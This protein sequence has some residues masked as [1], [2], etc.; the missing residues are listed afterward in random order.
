MIIDLPNIAP[1]KILELPVMNVDNFIKRYKC[2]EVKSTMIK[3]SSS[4]SFDPDGL[5]SEI[6]FGEV[7]TPLRFVKFGYVNL[8][9]K[10]L[11][12]RI[13]S[14]VCSIKSLYK[15]ILF[16]QTYAVF[17][18]KT[19]MFEA[20]SV[21]NPEADT[22]LTF[23]LKYFPKAI[24]TTSTSQSAQD[25]IQYIKKFMNSAIIDKWIISPPIMREFQEID[26]REEIGELNKI[27]RAIIMYARAIPEDIDDTNIFNSAKSGIQR[28][29]FEAYQFIYDYANGKKGA[30]ERILNRRNLANSTRNVISTIWYHP[31]ALGSAD[32]LNSKET[33]MP[34]FQTIKAYEPLMI[35]YLIHEWFIQKIPNDQ[36]TTLLYDMNLK[37]TQVPITNEMRNKYLNEDGIGK[38]I[39]NLTNEHIFWEDATIEINGKRYYLFTK[40][41]FENKFIKDIASDEIITDTNDLLRLCNMDYL[42]SNE[43]L[44]ET[45]LKFNENHLKVIN[46]DYFVNFQDYKTRN[47]VDSIPLLFPTFSL[48]QFIHGAKQY[49]NNP[50]YKDRVDGI[51]LDCFGMDGEEAILKTIDVL[52]HMKVKPEGY[53]WVEIL[54]ITALRVIQDK[55][56][57][58]TRYPSTGEESTYPGTVHLYTTS[59]SLQTL[60]FNRFNVPKFM[61]HYPNHNH[62]SLLNSSI[63][64]AYQ[65]AG[66][67]ADF[68]GDTVSNNSVMTE[69]ANQECNSYL[70]E[71]GAVVTASMSSRHNSNEFEDRVIYNLTRKLEKDLKQ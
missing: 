51:Y 33:G 7:G 18:K 2:L 26:G 13:F 37:P 23:F 38:F 49:F 35:H 53:K 60:Y 63:P 36:N 30:L 15:G 29:V 45:K 54:Y 9:C 31:K 68:D 11:H 14:L 21:D 61:P 47:N 62:T 71:I 64:N 56:I 70:N 50:Q 3:E 17:N 28:K 52:K 4:D 6:I 57:L 69:E 55:I 67:N 25:N 39:D 22:G 16:G 8:K 65:L 41:N 58:S 24:L 5:F 34:L 32:G 20:S 1:N 10:V 27:Y 46:Y 42:K 12:P 59:N 40:Y 19:K 48:D 44:I 66:L 43:N